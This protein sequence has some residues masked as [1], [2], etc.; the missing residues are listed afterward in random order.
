MCLLTCPL[1][2]L[3]LSGGELLSLRYD[4]TVP[5]ARYM[6][7]H[8]LV[9]LKRYQIG[10][11]Y[12]RDN[13]AMDRGRFREFYQCDFDI[14]GPSDD[15]IADSECVRVTSE[16]L[17]SVGLTDFVIKVNHRAVID[18]MFAVCGVPE[19]LFRPICSA[20]D[21]LDK[22]SWPDVRKEMIE[23]GLG[24]DA[25]DK[26]GLF[27]VRNGSVSVVDKLLSGGEL[28]ENAQA[29]KGLQEVRLLFELCQD[30]HVDGQLVF[31]LSL[32]RGLDYYTGV[33]Y[34]AV[35][36]NSEVGSIAAGGRYDGLVSLL[37]D[38]VN[39]KRKQVPC[40]GVSIGIERIFA[41]LEKTS[42]DPKT[43]YPTHCY[44]ASVGAG[45]VR[46]RMKLL[47]LLWDAGLNAEQSYKKNPRILN[48]IQDCETWGIPI[49]LI[50]G[51]DE[52]RN[53]KVKLKNVVS[54]EEV[55]VEREE[56]V[57]KVRDVLKQLSKL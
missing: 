29:K 26:I 6:A 27:V 31:D 53:G 40:V 39:D 35:L 22:M 24:E 28:S 38:T 50:I 36:T 1:T 19:N 25:A 33:I 44:V 51:E 34:E 46:E 8:K 41:I 13:P 17:Q 30:M 43:L 15:M 57:D 55:V 52:V 20:V 2:D 21:K 11:V 10:K 4:L 12:R 14:A 23:K 32:A 42:S 9:R 45:M 5:F 56:V 7:Q 16:I 3:I 47:T 18:G 37:A 49:V 48:Q 54:R